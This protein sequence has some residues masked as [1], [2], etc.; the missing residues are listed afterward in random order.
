M[1]KRYFSEK[2][3]EWYLQ[4][5]RNLPWRGSNNA[6]Y[7]WL[8][9]IILQQTRVNQGLPYYLRFVETFPTVNDLAAAPEQKVL[10]LWQGLG[11]YTRA[12]NLHKCAKEIVKSYDGKFPGSFEK[13]KTLPGIGDYTAAAIASMAFQESVAV[14]D[15]NVFRVLSRI[16]GIDKPINSPDGK[17]HFTDLANELI[18]KDRPD[19]H[20]QAVME[21][22][23]LYCTPKSPACDG[24]IF[25]SSCF[26]F[27]NEL[28]SVL[29]VK[30]K[31][32]AARKR[33]FYYFAF[34]KGNSILMKKRAQKDIWHGLYD[35]YL[36]EKEKPGKLESLFLDDNLLKKLKI[37]SDHINKTS[38]VY[39]HVLSH[40]IIQAK[41]ILLSVD[42]PIQVKESGLKYFTRKQIAELPKPVLISSFLEDEQLL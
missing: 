11:Y 29:P 41:F 6:Y 1:D 13:L 8:S 25:V 17:K 28:Q 24:C 4:H 37:K 15:G 5:Q 9:E 14:V 2:V 23:A 7:I 36:V 3:V 19:L 35:F 39:K 10:R 34:Q 26:A 32:K 12:R 30:I 16:F 21:F 40:Q 31:S 33:Y 27:K 22:G 42:K 20:N 18:G 38:T